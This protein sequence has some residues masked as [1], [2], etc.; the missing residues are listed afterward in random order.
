MSIA[1]GFIGNSIF[2]IFIFLDTTF[3]K[4]LVKQKIKSISPKKISNSLHLL[5][6]KWK[7]LDRTMFFAWTSC[8]ATE[9]FICD[10]ILIFFFRKPLFGGWKALQRIP[11]NSF[12]INARQIPE[13]VEG[14]QY[15]A[16]FAHTGIRE[17]DYHTKKFVYPREM[18]D[19]IE[20]IVTLDK[21]NEE[22]KEFKHACGG[23]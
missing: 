11:S 8:L 17:K 9:N 21:L 23:K 12:A 20:K 1:F 2:S 15:Q 16:T 14:V 13:S 7:I 4:K 3:T 22:L 5:S 10:S 19:W 18:E 6:T